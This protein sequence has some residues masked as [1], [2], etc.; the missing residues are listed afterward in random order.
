MENFMWTCPKC[1]ER[2][3]DNFSRCWNCQTDHP[4]NVLMSEGN[5]EGINLQ[6]GNNSESIVCLRCSTEL[7][8]MGTKNFLEGTHWDAWFGDLFIN[9]ESLDVYACPRCGRVEFFVE[10]IGEDR[11]PKR[12]KE[13]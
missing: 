13:R 10:G 6:S 12:S 3:D 2:V 8:F 4:E 5:T 7:E 9:R 11:R 1:G